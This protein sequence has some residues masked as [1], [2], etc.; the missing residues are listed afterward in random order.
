MHGYGSGVL[1][2]WFDQPVTGVNSV[3]TVYVCIDMYTYIH[4]LLLKHYVTVPV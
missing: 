1:Q 2:H 3:C 4:N